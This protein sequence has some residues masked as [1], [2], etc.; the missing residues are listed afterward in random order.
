[1]VHNNLKMEKNVIDHENNQ[2]ITYNILDAKHGLF[3]FLIGVQHDE[4]KI[5]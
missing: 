4:L 5:I 1:M 3:S 2:S